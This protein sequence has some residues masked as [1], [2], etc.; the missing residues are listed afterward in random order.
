MQWRDYFAIPSDSEKLRYQIA[1]HSTLYANMSSTKK[2]YQVSD[3]FL[4]FEEKKEEET[5]VNQD[6]FREKNR[7]AK[8][9]LLEQIKGMM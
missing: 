6:D 7:K 3:F 8:A 5:A 2:E 4:D 9:E 1:S